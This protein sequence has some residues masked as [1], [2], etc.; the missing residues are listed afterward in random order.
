MR[1]TEIA[2]IGAGPGGYVAALRATQMG[3]KVILIEKRWL[4]GVCLNAGCIPTK[5]LLKSAKVYALIGRAHEFGISASRPRLDWNRVQAR[6]AQVVKQL[7]DGVA[8]LLERAGVEVFFGE[9]RFVAADTIEV[10]SRDGLKAVVADN[11]IIATGARPA[12]LSLPGIDSTGVVDSAGALALEKFPD[13]VLV[14]GGGAI[15]LEWASMFVDFGAKVTLIELMPRLAPLMD[16]DLGVGLA[17]NLKSRGV[18]I[19]TNSSASR[20]KP[21]RRGCRVTVNTPSGEVEIEAQIVLTAVGRIPNVEKLGLEKTNVN[22]S[23]NGIEVD[24]HMRTATPHIYAIGDAAAAGPM[25]AHVASHQ[26][27]VAVENALGHPSY[28]DYS[29]VPNCIFTHPEAAS[30]GLTEKEAR[31]Q[32]HAVRVGKFILANNGKAIADGEAEGFVKIVA[33]SKNNQILGVHLMGPHASDLVL[34]GTLS[35]RLDATLD[36]MEST[37]HPHPTMGEAILEAALAVNGRALHLPRE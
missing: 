11:I 36:E 24:R 21:G 37:I 6:Q 34:E 10:K 26:G 25:L 7:V 8:M 30:V 29:A 4:G 27:I 22:Y 15:G 14:I 1:R 17:A 16:S 35:I 12:E 31:A 32:G 9:A 28:M 13:S 3:A 20:I 18:R 33:E 19:L 23:K 5:A 2:I